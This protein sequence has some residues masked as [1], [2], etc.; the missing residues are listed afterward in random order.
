MCVPENLNEMLD[1]ARTLIDA[2]ETGDEEKAL[3]CFTD[4]CRVE[5]SGKKLDGL[6]GAKNWLNWI[7]AHL[8][9]IR[10]EER[11]NVVDDNILVEEFVLTSQSPDG[12][13]VESGHIAIFEYHD[14]SLK[15]LR[16]YFNPQDFSCVSS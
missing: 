3:G 11:M 10:F 1:T 16:H 12:S 13:K 8:S 6:D 5:F 7:H 15:A 2:L 9:N 14:Y 4:D